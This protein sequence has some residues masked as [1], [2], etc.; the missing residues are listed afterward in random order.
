MPPIT[1][2]QRAQT[3]SPQRSRGTQAD[4]IQ[5][6]RFFNIW[7]ERA[8]HDSLS[9]ICRDID[10]PRPTARRWLRQREQLGSPA[11]RRT[12]K[13]SQRLGKPS[14]V[15]DE[16]CK[17]LVSPSRNPVR[18]QLYEAQIEYHHLP[19]QKRQLQRKLKEATNGGQRYKQAYIKKKLSAKNKRLRVAYGLEHENKGI[20]D[21]WQFHFFIDEAHIDPS[22]QAQGNI[23]REQ[24]TCYVIEN[25]QERGEKTGVKLHIAA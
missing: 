21:F 14:T 25:I 16:T 23:L 9:S 12:R 10:I 24:G 20:D 4:T 11:Y 1:R 7:D 3:P 19:I 13:L 22:S 17:L 18:D 2:S 15:S 5:K 8:S 6:V